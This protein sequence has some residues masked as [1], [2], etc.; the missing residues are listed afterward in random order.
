MKKTARYLKQ[1][2]DDF[3]KLLDKHLL[4]FDFDG[5]IADTNPLHEAAFN[6]VL[7]PWG[8]MVNYT[9][10][11]GQTTKNALEQVLKL[12]NIKINPKKLESIIKLK[13]AYA[14]NL[15]RK[16]L[17]PLV[18]VDNFLRW[19]KPLFRLS[20]C[21][22]GSRKTINIGLKALGYSGWFDPL[23]CA[24]DVSKGKPD[25]EGFLRILELCREN[26]QNALI[27]E[28]SDPGMCAAKAASVDYIDVRNG[29]LKLFF[30]KI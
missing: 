29:F 28:D 23:V 27:F 21:T 20:I 12:N 30:S 22:S 6:H 25:P 5:T 10:I 19:S 3:K 2:G 9:D 18:G 4:I 14:R 17:R 26:N 13:Q 16:N 7:S 24:E 15:I 11:A 1:L 8:I